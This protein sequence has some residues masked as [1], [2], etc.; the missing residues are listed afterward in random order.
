MTGD[1]FGIPLSHLTETSSVQV[2]DLPSSTQDSLRRGLALGS[3][4]DARNTLESYR[5]QINRDKIDSSVIWSRTQ[6]GTEISPDNP[7]TPDGSQKG[8]GD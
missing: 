4:E 7:A 1:V 5:D 3:E 8:S 6:L 2:S